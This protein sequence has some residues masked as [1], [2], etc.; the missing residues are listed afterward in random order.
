MHKS[1]LRQRVDMPQQSGRV[2]VYRAS[3]RALLGIAMLN[4]FGVLA[5]ERLIN[6][7]L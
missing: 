6:Q 1:Q 7:N 3:D 5:P 4:S 2:R